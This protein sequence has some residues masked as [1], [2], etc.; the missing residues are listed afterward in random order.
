MGKR[1]TEL[2]IVSEKPIPST[3]GAILLGEIDQNCCEGQMTF[4]KRSAGDE[5]FIHVKGNK[6]SDTDYYILLDDDV[7]TWTEE[8][9]I[10]GEIWALGSAAG[11]IVSASCSY[12]L[13]QKS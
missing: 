1:R 12:S 11:S 5:V 7:P 13:W 10:A 3:D 9:I 8:G 2:L 6:P 4:R